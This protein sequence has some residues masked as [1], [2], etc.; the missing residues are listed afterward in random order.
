MKKIKILVSCA[1]LNF[2]FVAGETPETDDAIAD[3]LIRAGHAIAVNS[4][5]KGKGKVN[6]SKSSGSANGRTRKSG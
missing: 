6:G 3:D 1:G 5:E 4:A 2:S